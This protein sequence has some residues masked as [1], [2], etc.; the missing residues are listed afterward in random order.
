[1]FNEEI[2][3]RIRQ[4][5]TNIGLRQVDVA[6]KTGLSSY[7][8]K[9]IE[10]GFIPLKDNFLKICDIL[11]TNAY[12]ILNGTGFT[13]DDIY[14]NSI[15][16]RPEESDSALPRPGTKAYYDGL[17]QKKC[18]RQINADEKYIFRKYIIPYIREE[19][20]LQGFIQRDITRMTGLTPS[21]LN[22]LLWPKSVITAKTFRKYLP[23]VCN[24][25]N[26]PW[27]AIEEKLKGNSEDIDFKRERLVMSLVA[28]IP[29]CDIKTLETVKEI[30]LKSNT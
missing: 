2:G 15:L 20:N 11:N 13:I 28:A 4:K 14:G 6:L 23:I 8:I 21:C 17:D 10:K 3:K 5:R 29:R 9:L 7:T 25:L 27:Q 26:I 16:P 22:R 18:E 12:E 30:I 24:C 19:M 1:M